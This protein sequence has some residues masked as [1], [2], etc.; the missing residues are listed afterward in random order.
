[1][2]EQLQEVDVFTGGPSGGQ[3]V[4]VC[5]HQGH[6][7]D[8]EMRTIAERAVDTE[9]VFVSR[10]GHV[11]RVLRHGQQLPFSA[12]GALAAAWALQ[13]DGGLAGGTLSLSFG[14]VEVHFDAQ[15]W[16]L[17]APTITLD[18]A[19]PTQELYGLLGIRAAP[20]V[21]MPAAQLTSMTVPILLVPV[22]DLQAL[23]AC[24]LD[25][26]AFKGYA[27]Q[28]VRHLALHMKIYVFCQQARQA[29]HHMAA[30]LLRTGA[31]DIVDAASGD[32]AACLGAWLMQHSLLQAD[33]AAPDGLVIEQG[34]ELGRPSHL[35]LRSQMTEQG[36]RIEVGGMVRAAHQQPA[37]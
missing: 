8:A 18:S 28:R 34:H 1:M 26:A 25:G 22:P 15:T 5:L 7:D 12:T 11:V 10:D 24:R 36:P 13:Q 4:M 20:P 32:A 27:V 33:L 19:W 16:W 30:R 21:E 14:D 9:I 6:L 35:Q 23:S 3:P 29:G 37:Q 17:T 2:S 31:A